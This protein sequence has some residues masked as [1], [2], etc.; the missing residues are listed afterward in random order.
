[1]W[2]SFA[3]DSH[4]IAISAAATPGLLILLFLVVFMTR[5]GM[6]RF[7]AELAEQVARTNA[8]ESANEVKAEFLAAMSHRIHTPLKAIVGFSALA[9][10]MDLSPELRD[11]MNTIRMSADWLK[12]VANDVLE[13]SSVEAGRLQLDNVP[14][15]LSECIHSAIKIVEPDAAAKNLVMRC[16]I[17]PRLPEIVCGDPMPLRLMSFNLLENAIRFTTNGGIVVSA[18]LEAESAEDV[19]VHVEVADTGIGMAADRRPLILEPFRHVD[20]GASTEFRGTGVALAISKRLFDLMGGA[21]AF[22]S[23]I[24]AGS[25]FE[26]AVPFQ[27]Q[28]ALTAHASPEDREKYFETGMDGY[29]TKPI[30][31]DEVLQLISGIGAGAACAGSEVSESVCERLPLPEAR[32]SEAETAPCTTARVTP[33]LCKSATQLITDDSLLHEAGASFGLPAPDAEESV[34]DLPISAMSDASGDESEAALEVVLSDPGHIALYSI[35]SISGANTGNAPGVDPY[36][37][38]PASE[39]TVETTRA[40]APDQARLAGRAYP[41]RADTRDFDENARE[42]SGIWSAQLC[43]PAADDR[44]REENE[45]VSPGTA[46]ALLEAACQSASSLAKQGGDERPGRDPFEQ[47]RKALYSSR[48]DVRVIH[49]NGDPSDRDLI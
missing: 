49:N 38:D 39:S 18:S 16:E 26:F 45:P 41:H 1:M 7:Q 32:A 20:G 27:K 21:I 48:F 43:T 40:A 42:G 8:A 14:F 3:G 47:A 10:K 17:D 28:N 19:I 13:S 5:R 33:L 2:T 37:R 15:S 9:L 44:G 11:Y 25:R 46:L 4:L 22:E 23:E 35:D 6:R 12:H 29:L 31:M 24:G 34:T 36:L 30:A